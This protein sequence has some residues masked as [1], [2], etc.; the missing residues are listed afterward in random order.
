MKD[1]LIFEDGKIS[2]GSPAKLIKRGNKR[3]LIEFVKYDYENDVAIVVTEWFKLF[4]PRWTRDKKS[5]KH[6]NKRKF[7]KYCH[8]NTNEF[9]SDYYQTEE[10]AESVKDYSYLMDLME[11]IR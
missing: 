6:N 7:A 1:V 11:E 8:E 2:R 3:V 4:I 5:C 9:Y 10:F